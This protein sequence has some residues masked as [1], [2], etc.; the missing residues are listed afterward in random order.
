MATLGATLST[1]QIALANGW[2][3][4]ASTWTYASAT[5]ITVPAGAT[6]RYQKGMP[7]K[8]TA[9]SVV[10]QGYIVSI[11]DTVLTVVGDTLTNHTFTANFYAQSGTVPLGFDDWFDWASSP[12][13]YVT[14]TSNTK[15]SIRGNICFITVNIS[16]TSNAT[17]KT[18]T[19]PVLTGAYAQT[20]A[21]I[22]QGLD[23]GTWQDGPC[24]LVLENASTTADIRKTVASQAWTGSGSA[25]THFPCAFY[26]I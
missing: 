20:F 19:L 17:T 3:T 9:N 10:L 23:N 13:G 1:A 21:P 2:I 15:F 18:F 4:D 12:T 22:G 24:V 6:S 25:Q 14:P 5:S 8:L 26:R 7:F 11:A 16:G